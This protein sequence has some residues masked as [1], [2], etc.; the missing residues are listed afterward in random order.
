MAPFK[1][2]IMDKTILGK[3]AYDLYYESYIRISIW[4]ECTDVIVNESCI[5]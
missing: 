1:E 5:K 3:Q 4:T 2:D